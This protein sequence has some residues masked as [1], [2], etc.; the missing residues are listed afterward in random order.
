MELSGACVLR[1]NETRY[2]R[3]YYRIV[4]EQTCMIRRSVELS[5][6]VAS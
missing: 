5:L 3:E 4:Q 6:A 1:F 2:Y